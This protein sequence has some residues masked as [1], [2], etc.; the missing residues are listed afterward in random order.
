MTAFNPSQLPSS[1]NTLEK[2]AMWAAM[3]L[4]SM[5]PTSVSEEG[6][7]FVEKAATS[8][9]FYVQSANRHIFL[10]RLSLGVSPDRVAGGQKN[11]TYALDLGTDPIPAQFTTN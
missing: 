10:T 3:A 7:G 9:I 4:T 11:W 8:N 2:L 6:E 5:Y 1:V